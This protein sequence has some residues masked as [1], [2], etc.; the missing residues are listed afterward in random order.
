V[1]QV[2]PRPTTRLSEVGESFLGNLTLRVTSKQDYKKAVNRVVGLM[3]DP[4]VAE[5]DRAAI[6]R[7]VF[8]LSAKYAPRTTR[9][10]M[11]IL[12]MLLELAIDYGVI[13]T[14]PYGRSRL[15]LPKIEKKR[16]D[17]LT[18]D[19]VRRLLD[20]APDGWALFFQ[21]ALWSGARRG[22]LAGLDWS[23]IS[24]ARKEIT[25]KEQLQSG[26]LVPLK[27][28]AS[29]RVI[30]IPDFLVD[31]LTPFCRASGLVFTDSKG[32]PINQSSWNANVWKKT[33]KAAR[34]ERLTLH[35]LRHQYASQLLRQKASI[36]FV[37]K[38]LGHESPAVTLSVY[39]HL[40]EDERSE[41]MA[42]LDSVARRVARKS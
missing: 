25:I 17:P 9:K 21:V 33:V 11:L 2:A 4:V 3:G 18:D 39:S 38:V 37:S 36:V 40:I 35:D 16:F 15:R 22:E 41:A 26:K 24:L 6:D 32:G 29:Y 13:E 23:A 5:I 12:K 20:A 14:L 42:A 30:P 31:E 27:T 7:L 8:L 10:S 1:E 19:E 34:L 28:S